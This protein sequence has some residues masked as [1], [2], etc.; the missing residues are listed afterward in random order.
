[1]GSRHLRRRRGFRP[2]Q[3]VRA[4]LAPDAPRPQSR[5]MII[6]SAVR[7]RRRVLPLGSVAATGDRPEPTVG[8]TVV[9]WK[10]LTSWL[11]FLFWGDAFP[12]T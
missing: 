1:M 9:T 4:T 2:A 8:R 12:G 5:V 6:G 3:R 11:P 7:F 10:Q